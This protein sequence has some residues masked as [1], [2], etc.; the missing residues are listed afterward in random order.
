MKITELDLKVVSIPL[1]T[2]IPS[3][4]IVIKSADCILV[5]LKTDDGLTGE[6]MVFTLNGHRL[7][8]LHAMLRS[9]EPLV[10][11]LDPRMSGAF[12]SRAWADIAFLG[13]RGA[14]V[15][16]LSGI[17]MALWD[18]RGKQA[19]LNVSHLIGAC[20]ESLPIYRS[21]GLR[22]SS[23]ID[24][25]QDEAQAFLQQGYRAMKMS[26]GKASLHEDVER[27]RAVRQVIGAEVKLMADCN[28]QFTADRAIRLG[29]RLEEFEL[30]WIE[31]PVPYH[32]HAAEAVV[33]AALDTPIASGESEYARHGMLEMLRQQ[34]ADILMPD[35]QRMGGPTE[36]LKVAHLA[37]VHGVRISPHLFTEM[38]I[39]L[40]AALPNALIVEHMPWFAPLYGA[41]PTPDA[42][43]RVAVPTAP[44]W[45][46]SFDA[47]AV[48]RYAV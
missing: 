32:D 26:L 31:E 1:P 44:G 27:V 47:A 46:Y 6:G 40:A 12:W 30:A 24:Q 22:L 14:T 38:S 11:G 21:G 10:L 29:R 28:Q 5:S 33:A 3:A 8:M 18:L 15:V 23:S 7:A 43:G 39:S 17:D 34:S 16:G 48:K 25:L 13:H 35:L 20:H 2:P 4:R 36:F 19:G 42:E 41:A 9:L 37:D 45:G